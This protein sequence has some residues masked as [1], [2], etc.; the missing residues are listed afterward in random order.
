MLIWHRLMKISDNIESEMPSKEIVTPVNEEEAEDYSGSCD[1]DIIQTY[2]SI[3]SEQRHGV[4]VRAVK[5][6][7]NSEEHNKKSGDVDMS[8][9]IFET[10]ENESL[11]K[12]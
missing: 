10:S 3:E 12:R 9:T 8:R 1:V 5:E 11:R 4:K 7:G 2:D 6:E